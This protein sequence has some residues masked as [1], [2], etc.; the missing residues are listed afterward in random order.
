MNSLDEEQTYIHNMDSL[1]HC[2]VYHNF[3]LKISKG[4]LIFFFFLNI[5]ESNMQEL[6]NEI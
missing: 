5:S 4:N 2:T 1:I 6:V 3:I